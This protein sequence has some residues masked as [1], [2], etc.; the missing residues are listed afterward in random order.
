VI[1]EPGL[2]GRLLDD[3]GDEPGNLP[4][5]QFALT[6][7]WERRVGG[8]LSHAAYEEIGGVAGAL[9]SY[10]DHVYEELTPAE[11]E[12]ARRIFLQMVRPGEGTEDTRR[13]A[14]WDELNEKDWP[15]VQKL[16]DARLLV[17]DRDPAGQDT[18][19]IVHEALIQNWERLR[20]WLDEDRA[21]RTWQIRLRA[22]LSGWEV[23]SRDS[24]ALLRG[25]LLT[26]AEAW[27]ARRADE[28][29][30][31]ALAFIASS[32]Q[33]RDFQQAQ[34]RARRR[35]ERSLETNGQPARRS[36][37][38]GE[39]RDVR[40]GQ[41]RH[42][43]EGDQEAVPYAE[44]SPDGSLVV[45]AGRDGTARV[46]DAGTGQLRHTL[47]H[48]DQVWSAS[49]SPTGSQ[50]VTCGEKGRASVWDVGTG[51]LLYALEGHTNTVR[52]AEFSADASQILT[53]SWDGTARVWDART[54]QLSHALEHA[55]P[56][57]S[58]R[59]SPDGSRVITVSGDKMVKVWDAHTGQELHTL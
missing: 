45:T 13:L 46:W 3:A 14:T 34:A 28:L 38:L 19:E 7:L 57:Y 55:E 22:A 8:G 29:S 17:T 50:L 11:Q 47:E 58:A 44:F 24:G 30:P 32:L 43:L 27:A 48:A 41:P 31:L 33:L 16:A 40:S 35:R 25:A 12:G 26:E 18:V 2:V 56:V 59:F 9:T 36:Q 4:L 37:R 23:S 10:A 6:L 1:F 51:R 53:A 15:L 54:G 5:L 21:F 42:A 52:Y 49:F 39:S 20:A